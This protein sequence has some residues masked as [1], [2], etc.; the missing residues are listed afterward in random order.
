MKP[1]EE[2][3]R[4]IFSL[5]HVGLA[6]CL[7]LF[8]A[9]TASAQCTTCHDFSTPNNGWITSPTGGCSLNCSCT[10]TCFAGKPQP[11]YESM[12][13]PGLLTDQRNGRLYVTAV[14][15]GSP[16]SKAGIKAGD[17]IV[18]INNFEPG[19]SCG[20]TLW[21]SED[22]TVA[23]LT[24]RRSG[25]ESVLA[26]G[27]EPVGVIMARAI[28]PDGGHVMLVA[29]QTG[30]GGEVG[31]YGPYTIG[32]H[33]KRQGGYLVIADVLSGSPASRAGML[34]GD[35][36]TSIN[37]TA[38]NRVS[39]EEISILASA[40]HRLTIRLRVLRQGVE[41]SQSLSGAGMSE[42]LRQATSTAAP[43]ESVVSSTMSGQ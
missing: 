17:E 5:S 29:N 3:N 14:L 1:R 26:V 20:S 28:G 4:A 22:A 30:E 43:S 36:I 31:S 21:A 42:I 38:A 2:E 41:K 6:V 25:Q 15:P 7:G 39:A 12:M 24:I 9:L 32:F 13:H 11:Q 23:E 19:T 34:V 8:G 10:K 35:R 16:A 37:G 33:L 18:S 40:D 27:L